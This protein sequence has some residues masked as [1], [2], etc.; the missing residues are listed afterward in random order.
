MRTGEELFVVIC[1]AR[2]AVA[3]LKALDKIVEVVG[4]IQKTAVLMIR[5]EHIKAVFKI[6]LAQIGNALSEQFVF[7][8]AHTIFLC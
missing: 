7:K 6:R 8:P 3:A 5:E 2:V 1:N 4:M